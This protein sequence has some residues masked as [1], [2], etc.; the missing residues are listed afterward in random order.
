MGLRLGSIHRISG[1]SWK[2]INAALGQL[3]LFTVNNNKTEINLDYELQTMGSFPKSKKEWLTV[4]KY[5]IPTT[6]APGVG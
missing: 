5:N 1:T 4:S 2:E 6:N 3:I